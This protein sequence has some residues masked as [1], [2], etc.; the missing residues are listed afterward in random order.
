[1][2]DVY[3][4]TGDAESAIKTAKEGLQL[5]K[6]VGGL[7][8]I[9]A[10]HS[11]LSEIYED[12]GFLQEA[13]EEYKNFKAS[14]DSMFNSESNK[15]IAELETKYKTDEQLGRIEILQRNTEIQN[16]LPDIT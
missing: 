4:K 12:N 13:L 2:A 3:N 1:M 16:L 11:L 10:A 5:A 14:H 9:R 6:E 8:D 7:P 15:V